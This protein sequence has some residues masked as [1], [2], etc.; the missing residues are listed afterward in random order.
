MSKGLWIW[1]HYFVLSDHSVI[2]V[3]I[4]HYTVNLKMSKNIIFVLAKMGLP[5]GSTSQTSDQRISVTIASFNW[6]YLNVRVRLTQCS[7]LEN[8]WLM[9]QSLPVHSFIILIEKCIL[10]SVSCRL[11]K[12]GT[13]FGYAKSNADFR[14]LQLGLCFGW[15]FNIVIH[16]LTLHS[17]KEQHENFFCSMVTTLNMTPFLFYQRL[18]F[19]I[20]NK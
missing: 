3:D 12:D 10:E 6:F 4:V 11:R 14:E 5:G 1:F 17:P 13:T 8:Y 7:S 19:D 16:F 20:K 9:V 2:L 15:Y 18:I